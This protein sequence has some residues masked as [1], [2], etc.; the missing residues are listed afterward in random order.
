MQ[1][2]PGQPEEG[3]I[4]PGLGMPTPMG[5]GMAP[6][7]SLP[8]PTELNPT[9]HPPHRVAAPDILYIE[10]LRLV[11]KG[12]YKLAPME[13]LQIEVSDTLP[14]QDIKGMYMISPEGFV[15]LG[16]SYRSVP[17]PGTHARSGPGCDSLAPALATQESQRQ[18]HLGPNARHAKHQG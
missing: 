11:P 2:V 1:G 18:C 3:S 16:F 9:A 17:R 10:A 14:R 5:M 7:G 12:P 6:G 4:E 13:V 8:L 15:N